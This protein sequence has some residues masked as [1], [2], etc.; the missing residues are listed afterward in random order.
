[1]PGPTPKQARAVET[2]EGLVRAVVA[3]LSEEGLGG[4]RTAAVAARAGVSQ[5]ALFRHFPT[6]AEL[7]EAALE[8]LLDDLFLRFVAAFTHAGQ[9]DDLLEDGLREL[10]AV[11]TDPSLYGAF[12]LF[13][14]ARN[15][16][17]LRARTGPILA[18]H[19]QREVEVA[20][21]MFP[22]AAAT[23]PRFEAVVISLLSTLQGMALS[24]AAIHP[25]LLGT[26]AEN[27]FQLDIIV[28]LTR[29]ELGEP[30][31]PEGWP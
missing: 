3:I 18:A 27:P 8:R 31:L 24:V 21:L 1:M 12:E 14:A 13:V 25:D 28:D 4:V 30:V 9:G 6:K 16:A 23:H 5:G 10:W 26:Y 17:D 7:L 11:Y 2:R 22:E 20:R 15:D 19:A 29:R